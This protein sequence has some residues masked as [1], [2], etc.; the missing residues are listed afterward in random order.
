MKKKIRKRLLLSSGLLLIVLVVGYRYSSKRV[1]LFGHY[2]KVWAHRVDDLKKLE[3]AEGKFA[4]VE[5][6]LV[7][8]PGKDKLDIHHPPK[9]P[10]GLYFSD[11]FKA[12][13]NNGLPLWLDIKN[14]KAKNADAILRR[15]ETVFKANA[16]PKKRGHILVESTE[17]KSLNPFLKKGYR[18]SWY[19]QKRFSDE[20][21]K[22]LSAKI[23]DGLENPETELSSNYHNYPYLKKAFP[24]RTKNFWIMT[25]TYDPK[26]IKNY[27]LI[28]ELVSDKKVKTVLIPYVNFNRHY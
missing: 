4:G 17:V 25:S 21:S 7:Y 19:I 22:E 23:S 9:P 12:L 13:E 10:R 14:L 2:D 1:E 27:S 6:D 28:R 20:N 24:E 26:T 3:S 15:L 5:L 18:T 8:L 16:L 11:Y